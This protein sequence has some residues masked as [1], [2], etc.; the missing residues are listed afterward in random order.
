MFLMATLHYPP[1]PFVKGYP[2][3]LY[4]PWLLPGLSQPA[5]CHSQLP[6]LA[7]DVITGWPPDDRTNRQP[8]DCP[9]LL[10]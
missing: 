4:S 10:S 6:G 8:V 9:S 3:L 2:L 7:G 1:E 5:R